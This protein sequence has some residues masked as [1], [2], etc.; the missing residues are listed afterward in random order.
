[1]VTVWLYPNLLTHLPIDGHLD[2][3]SSLFYFIFSIIIYPLYTLCLR[4]QG[5][6]KKQI[7]LFNF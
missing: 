7:Q 1:M 4:L 6:S 2:I 3:F 5:G